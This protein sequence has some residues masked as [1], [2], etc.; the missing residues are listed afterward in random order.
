M[1][2]KRTHTIDATN[3]RLGRLASHIAHLILGKDT[4]TF[5]RNTVAPVEIVVENVDA[6]DLPEKKK[7]TK[8]YDRY[9]GFHGGR[10]EETMQEVIDKKG[11]REVL[12]KAVYNMLPNN[13]LRK[14]RMK[15]LI[16]K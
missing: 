11:T 5:A 12:T 10:K 3:Q 9:S 16:I 8:V 6:L 1:T 2:D 15:N 14:A 13:R 7:E 4:T